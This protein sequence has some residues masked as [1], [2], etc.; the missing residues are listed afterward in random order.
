M[1]ANH[2]S[3]DAAQSCEGHRDATCLA[4]L[5]CVATLS[6]L[7]NRCTRTSRDI[8]ACE[9]NAREE[10]VDW[11][12]DSSLADHGRAGRK[13]GTRLAMRSASSQSASAGLK[14]E[15]SLMATKSTI[16]FLELVGSHLH[17]GVLA[18]RR[19]IAARAV[20]RPIRTVC[21][22]CVGH[23][24]P[25][26]V[27]VD[28]PIDDRGL[29]HGICKSCRRKLRSDWARIGGAAASSTKWS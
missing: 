19:R 14:Q 21:A 28:V 9:R 11:P 5:R 2:R 29:S 25:T 22:W 6:H 15:V 17:R 4:S 7:M 16:T 8:S 13:T 1:I 23:N 12:S 10:V 20:M 27:L 3:R 26:A 18:D 24:R